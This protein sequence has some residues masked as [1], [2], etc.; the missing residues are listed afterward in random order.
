[1]GTVDCGKAGRLAT[2]ANA[3]KVRAE[4]KCHAR[5]LDFATSFR[6][7]LRRQRRI[8]RARGRDAGRVSG[9][10]SV[11]VISGLRGQVRRRCAHYGWSPRNRCRCHNLV[12]RCLLETTKIRACSSCPDRR[13]EHL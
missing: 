7:R 5:T 12:E 1:V 10:A 3:I 11:A 4:V 8:P 9:A 6:C 13:S 2:E